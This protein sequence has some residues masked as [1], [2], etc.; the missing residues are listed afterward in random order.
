MNRPTL[1][2][3][4]GLPAAASTGP[5]LRWIGAIAISRW[6]C[7]TLD[8]INPQSSAA[9][10][11][12]FGSVIY[13]DRC[14]ISGKTQVLS[15][16]FSTQTNIP[17]MGPTN[18]AASSLPSSWQGLTDRLANVGDSAYIFFIC[19]ND[20]STGK[21]WCPDVRAAIPAVEKYFEKRPEEILMVSVGQ[22]PE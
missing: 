2:W 10:I 7:V 16:N 1:A 13:P 22:R 3:E 6:N 18:T 5:L 17:E 12:E 14:N 9:S 21:P 4:L 15:R 11:L 20:A 19:D 8:G